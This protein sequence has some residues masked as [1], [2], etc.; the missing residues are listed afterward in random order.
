MK[1]LL[2]LL[3]LVTL[4]LKAQTGAATGITMHQQCH[5]QACYYSS[6]KPNK[7]GDTLIAIAYPEQKAPLPC[8]STAAQ[9]GAGLILVTD[10]NG[11]HWQSVFPYG[12]GGRVA[13]WYA[14]NAKAG[15]NIVG[16]VASHGY[17]GG[18]YWFNVI[19]AEYP[20]AIGVDV[21]SWNQYFK[22][23]G[24]DEPNAG[25]ITT[26]EPNDL[27]IGYSINLAFNG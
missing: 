4:P 6:W 22:G 1:K 15:T 12:T 26:T 20:P 16:V 2:F 13:I 23:E 14:L 11:N 21:S 17:G 27:L 25:P 8:E 9:C 24:D 10:L 5:A 19:I 3:L 7:A 18:D